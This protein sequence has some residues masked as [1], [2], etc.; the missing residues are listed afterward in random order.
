[1]AISRWGGWHDEHAWR[2]ATFKTGIWKQL[3][4]LTNTA[5]SHVKEWDFDPDSLH[6]LTRLKLV[7]QHCSL[8][9]ISALQLGTF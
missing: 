5:G 8:L 4:S 3:S 9:L 7:F 2:W 1:M 6:G